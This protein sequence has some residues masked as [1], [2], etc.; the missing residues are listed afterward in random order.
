MVE[1]LLAE[2]TKQE[3]ELLL[4]ELTKQEEELLPG[5]ANQTGGGA[6]AGGVTLNIL[7]GAASTREPRL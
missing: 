3:E 2:L 4:A 5:G 7:E 6:A 1:L